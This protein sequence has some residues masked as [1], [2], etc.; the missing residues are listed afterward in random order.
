MSHIKRYWIRQLMVLGLSC[1]I[2]CISAVMLFYMILNYVYIGH[3]LVAVGFPILV[4]VVLEFSPNARMMRAHMRELD[5]H[6]KAL[7]KK[8]L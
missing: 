2:N 5:D 8:N 1:V 4:A 3:V 6:Y 7:V